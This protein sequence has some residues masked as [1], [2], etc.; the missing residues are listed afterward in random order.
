[1]FPL[2]RMLEAFVKVGR[3]TVIDAEGRE[4]VFAGR[5]GRRF[6]CGSAIRRCTGSCS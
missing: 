2:S 6:G 3:L 4:H 5:P 1:M